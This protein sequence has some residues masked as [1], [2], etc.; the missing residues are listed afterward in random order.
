MAE[1]VLR[2]P[3]DDP[4]RMEELPDSARSGFKEIDTKIGKS[5]T[6]ASGLCSKL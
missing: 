6:G 1:R 4:K 3:S 2:K 5:K